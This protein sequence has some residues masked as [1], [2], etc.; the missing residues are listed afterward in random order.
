MHST[1]APAA[2]QNCVFGGIA[3]ISFKLRLPSTDAKPANKEMCMKPKLREQLR[4]NGLQIKEAKAVRE[5]PS[6]EFGPKRL[7]VKGPSFPNGKQAG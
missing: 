3:P 7:K 4:K 1:E 5:L 6:V 2:P